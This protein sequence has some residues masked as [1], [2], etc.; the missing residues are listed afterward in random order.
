M[1]TLVAISRLSDNFLAQRWGQQGSFR[2][3]QKPQ[4]RPPLEEGTSASGC[5]GLGMHG[6]QETQERKAWPQGALRSG[7][8]YTYVLVKLLNVGE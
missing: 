2:T 6:T 8:T 4:L 5:V 7:N 3:S 1:A